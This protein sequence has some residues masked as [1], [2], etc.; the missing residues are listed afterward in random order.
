MK[1]LL[2]TACDAGTANALIPVLYRINYPWSLYA[3]GAAAAIFHTNNIPFT[4]ID[5]CCWAEIDQLGHAILENCHACSVLSGTSW[6]PTID[7][8]ITSAAQ[9]KAIPSAAIIDHWALYRERFSQVEAG[10]IID[11]LAYLPDFIWLPDQIAK[12]ESVLQVAGHF[13]AP[14]PGRFRLGLLRRL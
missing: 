6:G 5:A 1:P 11:D 13:F 10:H 12:T 4:K 2:I 3:Q 14:T 8:A 7:K 9:T